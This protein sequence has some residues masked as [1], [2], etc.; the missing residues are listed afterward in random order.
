MKKLNETIALFQSMDNEYRLQMLLDY[1]DRLPPLPERFQSAAEI[2]AHR[3]HE[4]M[5]PVSMWVEIQDGKVNLFADAPRES[6]TVRGF[7]S[8]LI[9]HFNG[10]KPEAVLQA[11]R[12]IL[13]RSGLAGALGMRRIQGLTAMM[14]RIREAVARQMAK[15]D[16]QD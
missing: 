14:Q 1:A 8:L 2:E 16:F 10:G 15:N 11:P 4:C 6:P 7:I 3:L 5:T 12:D 13:Q 9:D